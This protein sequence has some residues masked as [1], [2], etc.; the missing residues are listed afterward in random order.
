MPVHKLYRDGRLYDQ[1]DSANFA[2]IQITASFARDMP[3]SKCELKDE[4][5]ELLYE[6]KVTVNP[7]KQW[8]VKNGPFTTG[9]EVTVDEKHHNA[10]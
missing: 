8:K 1:M 3:G 2:T 10:N 6:C 7:P 5:G 4:N 9:G